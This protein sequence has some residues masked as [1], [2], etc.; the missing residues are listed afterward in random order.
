MSPDLIL[1][2]QQGPIKCEGCENVKQRMAEA[3]L[4]FAERAASSM[5]GD[6][7]TDK[8]VLS[9][10]HGYWW[11]NGRFPEGMPVLVSRLYREVWDHEDLADM[12]FGGG[13]E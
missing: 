5:H 11:H 6:A 3:G 8:A 2:V 9:A 10:L 12:K 7:L 4:Q 1:Y 13:G